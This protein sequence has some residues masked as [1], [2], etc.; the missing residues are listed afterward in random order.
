MQVHPN[1]A[2]LQ[3]FLSPARTDMNPVRLHLSRCARCRE[4]L[5]NLMLSGVFGRGSTKLDD[6]GP[7]FERSIEKLQARA[8]AL[9]RERF[10]APRL[11]ARLLSL[12]SGQRRLLFRNSQHFRSWGLFELLIR[13]G[14]EETFSDPGHAEEILE[15]A[16]EAS[17]HLD[18]SF[19][20]REVL[21]DMR[22][23][24]WSY[25]ANA[26]RARMDL[27]ASEDAFRVAF[28]HLLRGTDDPLERA[29]LFDL[30]ASLHRSQ[31]QFD[32]AIRLSSRAISTFRKAG[33]KHRAGRAL[34]NQSVAHAYGGDPARAISL[35]Y[36]AL[37]LIDG[38]R[39]PR[40]MLYALHNL[41]DDLAM[42]G[43]FLEAQ[44]YLTRAHSLYEQFS[45]PVVQSRRLWVR[46]KIAQ[47]F[48]HHDQAI[49][50]L[51]AARDLI[52]SSG[53]GSDA[54]LLSSHLDALHTTSQGRDFDSGG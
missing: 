17:L 35:L 3:D 21:E 50:L 54:I 42:T 13:T 19:Y 36:K 1:D 41:I 29:L 14:R 31:R 23:R 53:W 12:H 33:D 25:I 38:D 43:R 15:L 26:R 39:E 49:A 4:R 24:I 2:S 48:G 8:A 11:L 20:G 27:Q 18:A 40:L 51:M 10:E 47:G 30:Q 44:R 9:E 32:R 16:L 6:Y 28:Q 34:V 7:V 45:S 52:V 37:P 5:S 22:A 46:A